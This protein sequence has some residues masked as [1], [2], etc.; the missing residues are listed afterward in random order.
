MFNVK[1][2]YFRII[3]FFHLVTL[4][5]LGLFTPVYAKTIKIAPQTTITQATQYSNVTL[6]LTNG[7]FVI[8]NQA[9]LTLINCNIIST[10][11]PTL[12]NSIYVDDGTLILQNNTFTVSTHNIPVIPGKQ[13]IYNVILFSKGQLAMTD[14]HFTIVQAY[15]VGLFS[16]KGNPTSN[17]VIQRNRIH[18]FHGGI[19]ISD[20]QHAIISDNYLTQISNGNIVIIRGG[21]HIIQNNTV[22]HS[23]N[24]AVGDA[25]DIFDADNVLVQNNYLSLG[26]CYIMLVLRSQNI[27]IDHNKII[28]GITY[29]LLVTPTFGLKN[30][31][32]KRYLNQIADLYPAL[33]KIENNYLNKNIIITNNY[34]TLNRFSLAIQST[35][36]LIVKNNVMIQRFNNDSDRQFW[37]NNDNIFK[38]NTQIT[39]ENNLYKEAYTQSISDTNRISNQFVPFPLHGGVI[40]SDLKLKGETV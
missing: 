11:T 25:I 39:W 23:G 14:N 28:G 27:I 35:E 8:S 15:T 32:L 40:L 21:N 29:A 37:T 19:Y 5:S 7:S 2:I 10:I 22:L 24:N 38:D 6:D 33:E 4:L 20:S 34:L 13:S 31:E 17:F 18:Q 12:P 30:A 16:T 36:G 9:T 1:P 26:S 3:L